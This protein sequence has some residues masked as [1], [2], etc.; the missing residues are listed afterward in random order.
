VH[1]RSSSKPPARCCSAESSQPPTPP[2]TVQELSDTSARID[3]IINSTSSSN[4]A[5]VLSSEARDGQLVSGLREEVAQK[6]EA[7]ASFEAEILDLRARLQA[8]EEL[9]AQAAEWKRAVEERDLRLSAL[10]KDLKEQG[11]TRE[12]EDQK[13]EVSSGAQAQVRSESRG[14]RALGPETDEGGA[15]QGSSGRGTWLR[16]GGNLWPNLVL[17]RSNRGLPMK[18]APQLIKL[19]L[20][21]ESECLERWLQFLEKLV[22]GFVQDIGVP[23]PF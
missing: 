4:G 3:E 22:S 8:A 6:S 13:Q 23:A 10:A 18:S 19:P 1:R 2:D 21:V 16:S 7:V 12:E 11:L 5:S 9:S 17:I 20:D 15:Q 14:P